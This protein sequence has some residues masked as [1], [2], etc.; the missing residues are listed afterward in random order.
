MMFDDEDED[1]EDSSD[2]S[3]GLDP[4]AGFTDVYDLD[5][6]IGIPGIET[7][8]NHAQLGFPRI[9]TTRNN[10]TVLSQ[11]YNVGPP[12][13]NAVVVGRWR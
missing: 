4:D 2:S 12:G 9:A 5:A 7:D 10:L 6:T 8:P 3:D 13:S 1:A 11:R